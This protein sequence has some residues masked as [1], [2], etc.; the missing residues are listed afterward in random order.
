MD[1]N[2]SSL[3]GNELYLFV[4]FVGCLLFSFIG[5]ILKE[6]YNSN[7]VHNYDF[8]PH[9]VISSTIAASLTALLIKTHYFGE[10]YGWALIAFG[11]FT[12]GLLG[13]EIFKNL[14]S[15]EGIKTLI[16]QFRDLM[17]FIAGIDKGQVNQNNKDGSDD[18]KP[19]PSIPTSKVRIRRGPDEE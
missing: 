2:L 10:E 9:R 16:S 3:I 13:F 19:E 11:S 4:E 1:N 5:S 7:T 8:A 18:E 6:V 17:A 12:L 14:C 15:I